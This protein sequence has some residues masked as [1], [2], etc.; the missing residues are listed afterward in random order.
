MNDTIYLNGIG[1]DCT[2]ALFIHD[3]L[4]T[5]KILGNLLDSKSKS[6]QMIFYDIGIFLFLSFACCSLPEIINNNKYI[7]LRTLSF[8]S[9]NAE[10]M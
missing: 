1:I 4:I 8:N 10:Q 6:G 5:L 9:L 7:Y 3:V 2:R